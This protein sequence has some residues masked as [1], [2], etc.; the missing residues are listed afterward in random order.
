MAAT[1]QRFLLS[2]G[3]ILLWASACYAALTFPTLTGRVVDDAHILSPATQSEMTQELA[4]YEGQ[5]TNQIVVVTL[6]SL[7]GTSI[8]D[9][10]Y[11]LGRAWHI[12]Q[13]GKDNGVLLIVAPTEHK[14]R[15]E[16]GY[17]L[18]ATLTDALS[19][20]IIQSDILP[21][22]RNHQMEQGVIAGTNAIIRV[23]GGTP[24]IPVPFG[25]QPTGLLSDDIN[26]AHDTS[27]QPASPI[28]IIFIVVWLVFFLFASIFGRRSSYG[29]N[30]YGGGFS[31][32]GFGGGGFSGGGGSFG[33]G[34]ASGSW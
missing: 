17:G 25:G 4:T 10:G 13:K 8:E 5:T 20:N 11:Q 19:S 14:V 6:P 34:G 31:S 21:A 24:H 9:Y 3:V 2:F 18:E 23:L 30:Y 15:I 22:F 27:S 29:S 16:V 33:G 32:G 1:A 7:Q 28:V 26:N 12:G